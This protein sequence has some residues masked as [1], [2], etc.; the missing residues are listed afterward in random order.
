M[1]WNNSYRPRV[2]IIEEPLFEEDEDAVEPVTLEQI[3]A[4]LQIDYEDL[5]EHLTFVGKG[6]RQELEKYL[7]VSLVPKVITLT[8][9]ANGEFLLP[10]GPVTEITTVLRR[11]GTSTLGVPEYDTVTAPD[12]EF[13]NNLFYAGQGRYQMEYAAG[14][15]TPDEVP[16]DIK[17]QL[18][19]LIAYRV[20]NRGDEEQLE[21]D[22]IVGNANKNYSWI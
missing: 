17:L 1:S 16:Y 2:G 11:T 6:C 13:N 10:Y 9:D 4:Q 19:R 12:Y 7:G 21:I 3:K 15:A 5:D 20:K 14:Y 22:R 8:I 18:L